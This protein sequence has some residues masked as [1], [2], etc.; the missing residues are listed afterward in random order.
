M[1]IQVIKSF[2]E[3]DG[4][5]FEEFL[6]KK[7]MNEI[8]TKNKE[9][10]LNVDEAEFK[11]YLFE[12]Y[13]IEPLCI[14][15]DTE[16]IHEPYIKKANVTN[17]GQTFERD[18]YVCNVTYNFTGNSLLFRI[19]PSTWIVTYHDVT[20]DDGRMTVSISFTL[21]NKDSNQFNQNK[22]RCYHDA[23]ANLEN[24]NSFA[25]GW[26]DR[27]N[28]LINSLYTLRKNHLL[29]ENS[30][31]QAINVKVN[32]NTSSVF[33]AP[34]I[35]KK[36]I[37]QPTFNKKTEYTLE[38]S[39]SNEMYDDILKVIYDS[40]KNMEKKPSLYENKDEEGLRDQFLFVLETRYEGTAATGETFNRG[41]K[42]D[43]ILKYAKDGSNL[44][45]AEC[46]FWNGISEFNNAISQ[47]FD[48]YLTWRDSKTALIFFV[49]NKDFTNV[50]RLMQQGITEHPYFKEKN[51]SRGETSFRYIFSLP[52]D[53]NKKVYLEVMLF[54]Y[55]KLNRA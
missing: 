50:I 41:G 15:K 7:L 23:F 14:L 54:H 51:G 35:K 36:I 19:K 45:V 55:D 22:E 3:T 12:E 39:M 52:Q 4:F 49:T 44:F 9:Y 24:A 30:F 33:S 48:R 42:T 13:K 18:I 6:K 16:E 40:G 32:K 37:P 27:L 20:I 29:E 8:K 2:S 10:F 21:D 11:A 17:Y 47:L 46:K 1:G 5:S 25:R 43:I 53:K 28:L 38:P 26:N 34:T 31:F